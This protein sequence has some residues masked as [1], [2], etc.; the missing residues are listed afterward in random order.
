MARYVVLFALAWAAALLASPASA[1]DCY[2]PR[3]QRVNDPALGVSLEASTD[4]YR[5]YSISNEGFLTVSIGERARPGNA[6]SGRCSSMMLSVTDFSPQ[7]I[8][9]VNGLLNAER[10]RVL[11]SKL[12]G[13]KIVSDRALKIAGYPARELTYSFTVEF[14]GSRASHKLLMIAR[15]SQLYFFQFTWSDEEAIPADGQRIIDSIRFVPYARDPNGV[16]RAMLE[17]TVLEY[18]LYPNYPKRTYFSPGLKAIADRKREQE[19]ALVKGYGYFSDV[20]FTGT[21]NGYRVFRIDHQNGPVEWLIQDDGKQIT[22][23][24]WRKL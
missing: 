9:D 24:T 4:V 6:I 5:N 20:R 2:G 22:A 17:R 19:R 14:F 21:R 15:D 13:Q 8:A 10:N 18:Y 1:R 11:A 12:N 3:W 7:R 16:S 23:L